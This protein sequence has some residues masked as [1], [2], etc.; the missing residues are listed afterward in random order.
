ME[1]CSG[2]EIPQNGEAILRPGDNLAVSVQSVVDEQVADLQRVT[3]HRSMEK[4]RSSDPV[5]LLDC[6][7]AFTQRYILK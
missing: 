1:H 3:S 7:R 4:L 5:T 2:C 6:F